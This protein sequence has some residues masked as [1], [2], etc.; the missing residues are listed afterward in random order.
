MTGNYAGLKFPMVG[1]V[2]LTGTVISDESGKFSAGEEVLVNS[3]GVGT[4]HYGGYAEEAR[5]RPQ[6]CLELP[7]GMTHLTAARIGTAGYTAAL[8][9][10]EKLRYYSNQCVCLKPNDD[11]SIFV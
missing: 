4:D 3:F 9:V 5:M 11:Y 8:C 2:D 6:W 1:G 7:Q 10:Q